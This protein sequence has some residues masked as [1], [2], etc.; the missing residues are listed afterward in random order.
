MILPIVA[1][2]LA[3]RG[4][5]NIGRESNTGVRLFMI[6]SEDQQGIGIER[7]RELSQ[8]ENCTNINLNFILWEG[9]P[10]DVNTSYCQCYEA[11]TGFIDIDQHCFEH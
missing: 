11:E 2:V 7:R 3:V 10:E 8:Q 5:I 9:D 6:N 4:E 1:V